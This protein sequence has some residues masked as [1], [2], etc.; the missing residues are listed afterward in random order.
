MCCVGVGSRVV[1]PPART[2]GSMSLTDSPVG[3]LHGVAIDRACGLFVRRPVGV[4]VETKGS[5][6][7]PTPKAVRERAARV[8][9]RQVLPR[10]GGCHRGCAMTT[11]YLV[12]TGPAIEGIYTHYLSPEGVVVSS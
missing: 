4:S 12:W 1:S 7:K 8:G 5:A 11:R 10:V 2:I 9:R 3:P 6:R